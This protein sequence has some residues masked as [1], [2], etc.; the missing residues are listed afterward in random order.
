DDGSKDNSL[1]IAKQYESSIVKVISQENQGASAARNRALK[2]AQGDFIQYLDA[3][4][5]LGADKIER[6]VKLLL[7]ENHDCI[8]SGEWSRFYNHPLEAL[9]I[10][11]ALWTDMQPV[12]WLVCAWEKHLM[13]PNAAWL[14]PIEI[15]EKAG[16]WNESLSLDDDGEYFCRVVLASEGV[17]FSWGAK[18]YYR[19]G[20]SGSLSRSKSRKAWESA[21]LS[22]SLGTSNLL[23][24]ENSPS[25]RHT[26]ATVFQRFIYAVHADA[27]DLVKVAKAKVQKFGGSD[28]KPCGGP[29]FQLLASVLGWQRAKQVQQLGYQYGYKKAAFGWRFFKFLERLNY[30]SKI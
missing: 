8:A 30:I 3:D 21:F 5:L 23:A 12:D 17:K 18:T 15:S 16:L 26:C 14:V 2:E 4:D 7:N 27:P 9:F 11:Q 29:M 19:S 20:N 22:L 1:A 25:T 28:L 10:P 24:T 6:Q 13:M